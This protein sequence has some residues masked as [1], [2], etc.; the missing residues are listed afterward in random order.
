MRITRG[1]L[2]T[3]DPSLGLLTSLVRISDPPSS[4]RH[5]TESS[6]MRL[7]SVARYVGAHLERAMCVEVYPCTTLPPRRDPP[8]R[9][10]PGEPPPRIDDP[11]PAPPPARM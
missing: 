2:G 6:L 7:I 11:R 4:W 10:V 5:L 8:K 3:D 1:Q 9:P